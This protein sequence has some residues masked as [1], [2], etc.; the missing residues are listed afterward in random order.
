MLRWI[1]YHQDQSDVVVLMM[2]IS[3]SDTID[4]L[5]SD[6]EEWSV[7]G[8]LH[9]TK[10]TMWSKVGSGLERGKCTQFIYI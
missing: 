5:T 2:E 4:G 9:M 6:Q 10:V 8:L 7:Q 1:S 3:Q